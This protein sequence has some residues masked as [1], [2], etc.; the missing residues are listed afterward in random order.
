MRT[1]FRTVPLR[2]LRLLV[3]CAAAS[4]A[5]YSA[6]C[7]SSDSKEGEGNAELTDVIYQGETNDEALEAFLAGKPADNAAH[8][9]AFDSPTEGAM[10]DGATAPTFSWHDGPSTAFP[11]APTLR[12]ASPAPRAVSSPLAELFGPE[13]AAHAHGAPFNGTGYW[14]VFS[15][16]ADA[17]LVRVFTG[18]TSYTPA[19]PDWEKIHKAGGTITVSISAGIFTENNLDTDGGPYKGKALTFT[20]K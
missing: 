13:R 14:L 6:S 20:V 7:S 4:A 2:G 5:L 19:A 10:L 17:K 3:L 9:P 16:S 1:S 18:E 8:A 15:G 12:F 11:S